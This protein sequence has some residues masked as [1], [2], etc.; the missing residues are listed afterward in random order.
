MNRKEEVLSPQELERVRQLYLGDTMSN[1]EISAKYGKAANWTATMAAKHGWPRRGRGWKPG[2]A[3][4][5]SAP[6]DKGRPL[7]SSLSDEL[8]RA[9]TALRRAG[10]VV[11]DAEI[12]DGPAGRG[13]VKVGGRN[14][15]PEE[16]IEMAK[17]AAR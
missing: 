17:A 1:L 10:I 12:T 6:L 7:P 14:V 13:L 2:A 16:V 5:G 3:R 8:E 9:K 11:F 4:K 15:L